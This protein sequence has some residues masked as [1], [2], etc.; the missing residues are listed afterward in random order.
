M[1]SGRQILNLLEEKEVFT[2]VQ[3]TSIFDCH[4]HPVKINTKCSFFLKIYSDEPLQIIVLLQDPS[5][6]ELQV[7]D[8]LLQ[9][10]QGDSRTRL[11]LGPRSGAAKHR[12][13][14]LIVE[15]VCQTQLIG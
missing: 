2:V 10:F 4:H 3:M 6:L 14:A 1:F 12:D 5:G 8:L 13:D 15:F 9:G 11:R 7:T